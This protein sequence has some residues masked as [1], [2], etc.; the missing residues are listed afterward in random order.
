MPGGM[1]YPDVKAL[2]YNPA[3]SL[4]TLV[5]VTHPVLF[6]FL[7]KRKVNVVLQDNKTVRD[8]GSL[9]YYA[10]KHDILYANV[11]TMRGEAKEQARILS[12]LQ[13]FPIGKNR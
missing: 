8:D 5:I 2:Y 11:E 3:L 1:Y 6:D 7:K 4:H 9:S 13:S 12:L 10:G